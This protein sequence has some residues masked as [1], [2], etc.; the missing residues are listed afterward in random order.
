MKLISSF[1]VE[2]FTSGKNPHHDRLI[3]VE[4]KLKSDNDRDVKYFLSLAPQNSIRHQETVGS[5]KSTVEL[6]DVL[7]V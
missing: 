5:H 4:A 6:S 7:S 3:E 2:Y 1:F